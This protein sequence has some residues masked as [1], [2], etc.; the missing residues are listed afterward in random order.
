[1]GIA[2]KAEQRQQ[3][4]TRAGCYSK[5]GDG[6]DGSHLTSSL[7]VWVNR[8]IRRSFHIVGSHCSNLRMKTKRLGYAISKRLAFNPAMLKAAARAGCIKNGMGNSLPL[9]IAVATKPGLITLTAM[10]VPCKSIHSASA[11]L[12]RA[13]LVGP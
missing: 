11:K 2:H 1:M 12:M 8:L 4:I 3:A 5:K 13:A 6:K 9:V 7:Y 10:P